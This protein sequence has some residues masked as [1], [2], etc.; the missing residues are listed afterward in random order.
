M[1]NE[2]AGTLFLPKMKQGSYQPGNDALVLWQ[3]PARLH[4]AMSLIVFKRLRV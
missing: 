2:F 4:V 3:R 1:N